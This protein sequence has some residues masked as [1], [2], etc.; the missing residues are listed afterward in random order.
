MESQSSYGTGIILRNQNDNKVSGLN[1][2]EDDEP[3][4]C[5]SANDDGKLEQL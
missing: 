5:I 2:R 4:P 1:S 3:A